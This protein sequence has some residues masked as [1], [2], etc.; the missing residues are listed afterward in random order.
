M[1]ADGNLDV[2]GQDTARRTSEFGSDNIQIH[3]LDH[4]LDKDQQFTFPREYIGYIPTILDFNKDGLLDI[5]YHHGRWNEDLPDNNFIAINQG[6]RQFNH[7]N[8][9]DLGA[10]KY[11]SRLKFR[12]LN[13]DGF[14][15]IVDFVDAI[16]Q[17]DK[18]SAFRFLQPLPIDNEPGEPG[19]IFVVD[20][21]SDGYQ[22]ILGVGHLGSGI[23]QPANLK[24]LINGGDFNFE[25][26]IDIPIDSL[27]ARNIIEIL[28]NDFTNDG[29]LDILSRLYKDRWML[30]TDLLSGNPSGTILNLPEEFN[31]VKTG[32]YDQDGDLDLIGNIS[33]YRL[34]LSNTSEAFLYLNDGSGNF[35]PSWSTLFPGINTYY[36]SLS[37][38]NHDGTMDILSTNVSMPPP[39]N[40]LYGSLLFLENNQGKMNTLPQPPVLLQ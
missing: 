35:T 19:D 20:V 34:H 7:L 5:Y 6:N 3:Y 39:Y 23:Y 4:Q 14:I 24:I 31:S 16:Y 26:T 8:I 25:Q 1:D 37:D 11:N 32:D 9:T 28:L 30:Y 38:H 10:S 27:A 17:N 13:N 18:D 22:D 40:Y 2:V 33:A 12:D 15:D 21:N 36:S 29:H